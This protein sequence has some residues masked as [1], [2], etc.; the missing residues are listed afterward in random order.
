MNRR[1]WLAYF[2]IVLG[3]AISV[4]GNVAEEYLHHHPAVDAVVLAAAAPVVLFVMTELLTTVRGRGAAAWVVRVATVAVAGVAFSTSYQHLH[5]LLLARGETPST[6]ALY[7]LG[8]D[9]LLLGS[10]AVLWQVRVTTVAEAVPAPAP[11]A[12]EA[13]PVQLR[14]AAAAESRVQVTESTEATAGRRT[15]AEL[16]AEIEA[17][18]A[19]DRLIRPVTGNALRTLLGV[20][21]V[22]AQRLADHYPE[23]Q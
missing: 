3:G 5:A 1:E 18:L 22:R 6:G 12:V 13:P 4:Y 14:T 8:I 23:E 16:H 9:G 2:G 10:A 7:P 11:V 15:D 20:G 17:A 21:A 19:A